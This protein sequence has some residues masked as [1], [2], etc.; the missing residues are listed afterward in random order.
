VCCSVERRDWPWVRQETSLL[1]LGREGGREGGRGVS[2]EAKANG[3]P[4]KKEK[5]E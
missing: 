2:G 4:K 3:K 5:K 1:G